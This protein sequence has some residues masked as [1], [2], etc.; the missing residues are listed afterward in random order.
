MGNLCSKWVGTIA[1]GF[2][3]YS[4]NYCCGLQQSDTTFCRKSEIFEVQKQVLS[5]IRAEE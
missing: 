1:A 4:P 5:G 2:K 3:V